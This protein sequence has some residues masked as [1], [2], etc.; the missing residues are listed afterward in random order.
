MTSANAQQLGMTPIATSQQLV[1]PSLFDRTPSVF[2]Q[3]E[4]GEQ[5][6]IGEN[7]AQTQTGE[8][9]PSAPPVP[10]RKIDIFY[11]YTGVFVVAFVVTLL[12]TPVMRWIAIRNGIVDRPSD[13]RKIH[14][15][16]VAYL[17]GVAV[18]LGLM[19]GVLLSYFAPVLSNDLLGFHETS[20]GDLSTGLPPPVPI[21]VLLGMTIIMM[22]GLVDDVVGTIPRLKIAGMLIAAAALASEDVGVKVAAGILRPTLGVILENPDLVFSVAG[23]EFD[24]IYWTGTGVIMA[25]V[26]GACNASN[27]IDGLDGL[28]SG[29][30]AIA[31][32]GL[33]V[34]A[35]AL[36]AIDDGPRDA[37]RIVLCMA[38]VG[39]CLGFIPHNFNPASIFLGDCGSLLLGYTTIVIVL[40]LGDTGQTNLVMAG[41][42]IYSIPIIDTVLAIVRRKL[43]RKSMSEPDDQHLHHMLKRSLGVKGA[44]FSLYGIGIGFAALGVSMS[45]FK[46]RVAYIIALIFASYIIVTAIKLARRRHLEEQEER[47]QRV[48]TSARKIGSAGSGARAGG[49]ASK[50]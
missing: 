30:T 20:F 10:P 23:F 49:A 15:R 6:E 29:V 42:V 45:V 11:G 3:P 21:S 32:I 17:G 12:A 4:P 35:L 9:E 38:L 41:L 34:I 26:L 13:P 37:Q 19:S 44:V 31:G 28:L 46:A 40:M 25:F 33:L 22:L 7:G 16:P 39:A 36:A 1:D 18:F 24:L 48:A 2:S 14:K 8:L 27:L 5:R 43:A 47:L 50:A